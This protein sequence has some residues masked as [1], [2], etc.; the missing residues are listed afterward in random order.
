[1]AA[2]AAAEDEVA[3]MMRG[4]R[5]VVTQ[6]ESESQPSLLLLNCCFLLFGVAILGAALG[7]VG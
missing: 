1:M 6:P 2:A 3:A 4:I 7:L 5:N